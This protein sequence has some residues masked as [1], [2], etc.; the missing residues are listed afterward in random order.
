MDHKV[1]AFFCLLLAFFVGG[2]YWTDTKW[3]RISSSWPIVFAGA[4]G[5]GL[6]CNVCQSFR[7]DVV[8]ICSDPKDYSSINCTS[9]L[10]RAKFCVVLNGNYTEVKDKNMSYQAVGESQL[11]IGLSSKLASVLALVFR[12][13]ICNSNRYN[14]W[15]CWPL[16]VVSI[17]TYSG[18]SKREVLSKSGQLWR[19]YLKKQKS[20]EPELNPIV[21]S[22]LA[23]SSAGLGPGMRVKLRFSSFTM[24]ISFYF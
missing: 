8:G 23:N 2:K 16:I 22:R 15:N 21:H 17:R 10:P 13:A 5:Q 18:D 1:S 24:N 19:R 20:F 11:N 6:F 4:V 7:S 9:L 3:G 12:V 14:R